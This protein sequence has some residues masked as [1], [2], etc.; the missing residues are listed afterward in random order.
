MP[1]AAI[2]TI[3]DIVSLTG[4]NRNIVKKGLQS[5]D[6][7]PTGL[8]Q[9][10][11]DNKVSIKEPNA[12]DIAF[13][14]APKINSAG[15]MG[16]AEDSLV[17]YMSE[18]PVEIKKH[19]NKIANHNQKR[20]ELSAVVMEDCEKAIKKMDLSKIRVITL[21]SKK[22]DQG[23]LGIACAKLVEEYNRPVFL[24][25]QTGDTLHGSGRSID[26]INIHELLSSMQD[27][28]ETFGGHTMAAGLTLKE[29]NMKNFA[30]VSMHFALNI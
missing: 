27:I 26:D 17:L 28:L 9:L 5:F 4:E 2:A 25:S 30:I 23:I 1:I 19:L 24:F 3:A 11:K 8:K 20:Q 29:K 22:W 6:K 12:T 16:C 7:L 21:A 18:D 15:R 13:K 10:F 14:V